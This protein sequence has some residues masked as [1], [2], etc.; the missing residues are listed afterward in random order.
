MARRESVVRLRVRYAE[1]DHMGGYYYSRVLEWFEC[2]RSE[3]LRE[4]GVPYTDM[5]ARGVLLPV[6]EAHV[7]Y[8]AR[9]R[10]DDLL[11]IRTTANM[12][13]KASVRFEVRIALADGE[14]EGEI[15]TGY[16]VHAVTGPSGK[17]IRAPGWLVE[18]LGG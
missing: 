3:L 18:A 5:V 9:A 8:L 10:Y 16:T 6:V 13:G 4:A 7:E 11:E 12:S 2:G 17:P 1:T 14:A 15:A